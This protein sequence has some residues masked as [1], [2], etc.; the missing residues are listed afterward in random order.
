MSI[1]SFPKAMR[2]IY[3]FDRRRN[4]VKPT[5]TDKAI[6]KIY[7]SIGEVSDL[8]DVAPSAIRFW[9]QEFALEIRKNRRG[10]R[11]FTK[12][13]IELITEIHRLLKV[14]LYTLEGARKKL[15]D[16]AEQK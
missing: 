13:D 14:E 6:E 4:P 5:Q 10:E 15:R 11:Q 7:F 3:G 9:V 1:Q 8:F 2:I 16:K 12:Q